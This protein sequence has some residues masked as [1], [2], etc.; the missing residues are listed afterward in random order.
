M[1]FRS[2]KFGDPGAEATSAIDGAKV[3]NLVFC[4]IYIF[5]GHRTLNICSTR[6]NEML[7]VYD[8]E[9]RAIVVFFLPPPR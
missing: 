5:C 3:T 6:A 9:I 1:S 4:F 2:Q 7:R 8:A